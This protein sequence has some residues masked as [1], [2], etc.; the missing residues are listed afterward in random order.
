MTGETMMFGYRYK[1]G[2]RVGY[3]IQFPVNGLMSSI[4]LTNVSTRD[5]ARIIREIQ[6]NGVSRQEIEI[7]R[8]E[9]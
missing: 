1:E 8:I 9:H 4:L 2:V 5:K 6:E 7:Q 3:D